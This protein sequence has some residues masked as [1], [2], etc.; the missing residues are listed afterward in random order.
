MERISAIKAKG[1]ALAAS[2]A[3][4]R[5]RRIIVNEVIRPAA[6]YAFPLAPDSKQELQILDKTMA[7]VTRRC[8]GLP[9]SLPTAAV[10]SDAGDGGLGVGSFMADY[11]QL[12]CA[13]L[14]KA[15]NDT[16]RL[17]RVTRA[18]LR[19]QLARTGGRIVSERLAG[20]LRH[21]TVLRQLSLIKSVEIDMIAPGK[22]LIE[23]RDEPLI[24]GLHAAAAAEGSS[25]GP[26]VPDDIQITIWE[27]GVHSLADI[28]DRSR[29]CLITTHTLALKYGAMVRHHHKLALNR[30]TLMLC[31]GLTEGGYAGASQRS[32]V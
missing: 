26:N 21:Y 20:R 14:T 15:L 25:L 11:V 27:L 4:Y 31:R 3:S 17:G 10:L 32:W 5:H 13:G 22:Q 16:G 30:L 1:A 2:F 6:T 7:L 23:L 8:L 19:T 28:Y 24:D 12:N 29:K 9:A 18:L